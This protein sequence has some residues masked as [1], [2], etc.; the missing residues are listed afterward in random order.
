MFSVYEDYGSGDIWY[1]CFD[2]ALGAVDQGAFADSPPLAVTPHGMLVWID[3][4]LLLV[5]YADPTGRDFLKPK[6][7]Y[8]PM[9]WTV[10]ADVV[11]DRAFVISR[12]GTVAQVNRISMTPRVTTHHVDLNGRVFQA[13]WA[14]QEKIA[15][16]GQDGLGTIDTRT[17]TTQSIDAAP[18]SVP[19]YASSVIATPYGIVSWAYDS[20]GVR[21]YRP[22]GSLRFTALADENIKA[23]YDDRG[24][25]VPGSVRPVVVGRYLYIVGNRRTTVDLAAGRV[26][27]PAR[28]DAKVA[29]PSYVPIP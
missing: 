2:L 11:H 22:D 16:W 28:L 15:V 7:L 13:A 27:G 12:D 4:E 17:W 20:P 10:V 8:A 9:S 29:A 25:P 23:P 5:R 14:G 24:R 1:E 21:V 26:V 19:D 18:K 3:D 6:G